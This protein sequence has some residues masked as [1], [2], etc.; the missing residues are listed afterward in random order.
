MT[1]GVLFEVRV[2]SDSEPE[3][4]WY[5]GETVVNHGGRFKITTQAAGNNYILQLEIS[6]ITTEDGGSYKVTAKN[7]HGASS[8][9]L[10]LNLAGW[11]HRITHI[12][13]KRYFIVIYIA[14]FIE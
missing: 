3:V 14:K 5:N 7:S 8:A 9:G 1:G 13:I 11:Y 12:K 10:N 2:Q 4:T 6:E